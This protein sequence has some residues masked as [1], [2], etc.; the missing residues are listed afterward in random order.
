MSFEVNDE[1]V[2]SH[3]RNGAPTRDQIECLGLMWPPERGWI[4]R[5]C[6]AIITEAQRERFELSRDRHDVRRDARGLDLFG[7]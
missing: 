1:W 2:R 7:N 5:L 4:E 6:G 3:C